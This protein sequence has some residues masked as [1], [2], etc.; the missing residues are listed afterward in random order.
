MTFKLVFWTVRLAGRVC[1][2]TTTW[3]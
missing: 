1:Y 3:R 2:Q